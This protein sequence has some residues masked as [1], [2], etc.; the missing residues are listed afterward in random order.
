M[1]VKIVRYAYTNQIIFG[2]LNVVGKKILLHFKSVIY[3][4]KRK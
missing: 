4:R 1:I 2:E 3:V